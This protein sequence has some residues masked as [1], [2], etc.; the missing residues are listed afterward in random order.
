MFA[1]VRFS[2]GSEGTCLRQLF[3]CFSRRMCS[4]MPFERIGTARLERKS[5][6]AKTPH[7]LFDGVFNIVDKRETSSFLCCDTTAAPPSAAI[8]PQDLSYFPCVCKSQVEFLLE[9]GVDPDV[10]AGGN[11]QTA[12]LIAARRGQRLHLRVAAALIRSGANMLARDVSFGGPL[13]GDVFDPHQFS[14]M[15]RTIWLPCKYCGVYV[16]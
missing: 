11:D 9:R 2:V 14:P 10:R 5:S 12:L 7:V 1:P 8:P 16:N 15:N 3:S 6:A 4:E 13:V